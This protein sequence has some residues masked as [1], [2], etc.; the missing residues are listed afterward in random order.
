MPCM[1]SRCSASPVTPYLSVYALVRQG[2]AGESLERVNSRPWNE[3]PHDGPLARPWPYHY[4]GQESWTGLLVRVAPFDVSLL[5][6]A[7][8]VRNVAM[9]FYRAKMLRP[10]VA[11]I[12]APMFLFLLW[13][14]FLRLTTMPLSTVSNP[15]EP[16]TLAPLTTSNN[17]TPRTSTS[18]YRVC[19]HFFPRSVGFNTARVGVLS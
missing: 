14:G 4:R 9:V 15:L 7:H 10:P 2:E 17:E 6:A 19:F 16:C 11:R 8:C 3:P 1:D 13:G 12:S 18:R 5:L